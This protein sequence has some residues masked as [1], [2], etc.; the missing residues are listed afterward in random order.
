MYVLIPLYE[1][2][3][4]ALLPRLHFRVEMKILEPRGL[5][6]SISASSDG[7]SDANNDFDVQAVQLNQLQ[8]CRIIALH[9]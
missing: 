1:A 9:G 4:Y 3:D 2:Y 6:F 8:L 7:V 5:K